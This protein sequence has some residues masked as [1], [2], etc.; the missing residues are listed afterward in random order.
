VLIESEA[1]DTHFGGG[2]NAGPIAS[3]VLSEWLK[4]RQQP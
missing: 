3:R 4:I 2:T 1:G